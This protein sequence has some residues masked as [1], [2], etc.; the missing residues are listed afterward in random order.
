MAAFQL[1][2]EDIRTIAI[3]SASGIEEFLLHTSGDFF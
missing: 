2:T 3:V 1:T